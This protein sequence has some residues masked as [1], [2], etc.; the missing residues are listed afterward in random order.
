MEKILIASDHGGYELKQY[1]TTVLHTDG[2]DVADCGPHDASNVD[3]PDYA[4]T[5]VK[6][7]QDKTA[8]RGILICTSGIGMSIAAN[9]FRFIRGALVF[10]SAMA[11]LARE[12]NDANV[13][14]FGAKFIAPEEAKKCVQA[15]LTTAFLGGR[16]AR[17]VEKLSRCGQGEK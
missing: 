17:R 5:L 16:H 4:Y 11:T 1:L 6:G 12:H 8:G 9:R 10:N 15:F 7:I 14:I 3:Y 13:L 2:Y